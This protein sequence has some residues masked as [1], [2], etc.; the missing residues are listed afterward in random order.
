MATFPRNPTDSHICYTTGLAFLT[1]AE[2]IAGSLI[3]K[4]TSCHIS[5]HKLYWVPALLQIMSPR[6][7]MNF[8][9][10]WGA[11]P[12]PR[13]RVLICSVICPLCA[14]KSSYYTALLPAVPLPLWDCA[15]RSDTLS[16]KNVLAINLN[17]LTMTFC[18]R[19]HFFFIKKMETHVIKEHLM[20]WKNIQDIL[21][22]EKSR[23]LKCK[24][25]MN[26]YL[27]SRIYSIRCVDVCTCML[28]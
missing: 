21:V 7:R 6:D 15:C 2:K 25:N 14:S 22:K 27:K 19:N 20:T 4:S 10:N 9:W 5:E 12:F 28:A 13:P 11:V 18:S 24:Y 26:P 1:P 23:L 3:I 17:K 8:A 16:I